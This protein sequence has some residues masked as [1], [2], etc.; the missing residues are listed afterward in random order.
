MCKT[1]TFCESLQIYKRHFMR[2]GGNEEQYKLNRTSHTEEN[3]PVKSS[4]R[5]DENISSGITIQLSQ[6]KKLLRLKFQQK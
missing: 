5:T 6:Q 3:H 4:Q 2:E 1:A